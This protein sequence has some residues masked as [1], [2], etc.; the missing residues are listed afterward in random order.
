MFNKKNNMSIKTKLRTLDKMVSEGKFIEAVDHYFS[1]DVVSHYKEEYVNGKAKKIEGLQHFL[2]LIDT[3]D[4]V[5]FHEATA[6]TKESY[7]LFSFYFTQKGGQSLA[8][9]EVIRRVWQK[10]LVVEEEYLMAETP[11]DAKAI[12]IAHI[13]TKTKKASKTT[14]KRTISKVAKKANGMAKKGLKDDLK[15]IEGIGPKIAELLV[16]AG[17]KTFD[18]L[19]QQTPEQ[20]KDILNAAGKRFRIHAPQTWPEQAKMAAEGRWDELKK[21]QKE[22]KGGKK[23]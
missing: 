16:N 9:H 15:K 7:S 17:V 8:W 22:L 21:W 18:Q 14:A 23:A 19:S 2:N 13:P 1:N 3:V 20:I 11:E 12:Y 5:T 4:E 10:G 6:N